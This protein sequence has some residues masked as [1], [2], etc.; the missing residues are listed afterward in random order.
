MEIN[1][2]DIVYLESNQAIISSGTIPSWVLNEK[3]AN[4]I[5]VVR[6]MKTLDHI[7]PIG[8]RGANRSERFAALTIKDSIQKVITAEEATYGVPPNSHEDTIE[9]LRDL[10][11]DNCWG[12]GGSIGFTMATG[13]QACTEYSDVDIILYKERFTALQPLQLLHEKIQMSAHSIDVQVEITNLGACMLNEL[14]TSPT[15]LLRTG[16]GVLLMDRDRLVSI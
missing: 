4:T 14:V 12:I 7:V 5:A 9:Y 3:T 16:T 6:R 10:L 11:K 13:I 2:H 15:V 1:V 8:F